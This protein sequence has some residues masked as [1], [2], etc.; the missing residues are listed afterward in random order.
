[1]TSF[2]L[3]DDCF[4]LRGEPREGDYVL[5]RGSDL[6]SKWTHVREIDPEAVLTAE[7]LVSSSSDALISGQLQGVVRTSRRVAPRAASH[8]APPRAASRHLAPRATSRLAPG[9]TSR[10]TPSTT[11]P[12]CELRGSMDWSRPAV[13]WGIMGKMGSI[14]RVNDAAN[15]A[16][17]VSTGPEAALTSRWA[18]A[19]YSRTPRSPLA[20]T[21]PDRSP[22]TSPCRRLLRS[23]SGKAAA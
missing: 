18:W 5:V 14:S 16:H 17:L 1:M 23:Q 15:P 7:V 22:S 8:L 2:G 19:L 4:L 12:A 21:S 20:S 6:D 13:E 3:I 10:P 9:A 11:H